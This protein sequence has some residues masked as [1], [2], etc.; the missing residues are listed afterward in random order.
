[1]PN[2][3][4]GVGSFSGVGLLFTQANADGYI[5]TA[6]ADSGR[7]TKWNMLSDTSSTTATFMQITGD[8][9]GNNPG[10][11]ANTP[12]AGYIQGSSSS[13]ATAR[14]TQKILF[15]T[16]VVSATAVTPADMGN[17]CGVANAGTAGYVMG[18]NVTNFT[19]ANK[20]TYSNETNSSV[21]LGISAT[22]LGTAHSNNGVAAY[23]ANGANASYSPTT[24]YQKIPYSTQSASSI[25]SL[26]TGAYRASFANSGTAGYI[27]GGLGTSNV[28]NAIT[29][30]AYSSDSLSTLSATLATA[31]YVH[32]GF[33]RSGTAGYFAQ[34]NNASYDATGSVEKLAFSND[35]IST[36][37]A[38]VVAAT[39]RSAFANSGTL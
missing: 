30:T 37:A 14:K 32:V 7:F 6:N 22:H 38:T 15:S 31:R 10:T 18:G 23:L 21:S 20:M 13:A 39:Q 35:T 11:H 1:M 25:T 36:Q 8:F 19:G 17:G 4:S 28:L 26:V 27:G 34:G 5:T 12:V 33:A 29:K 3:L 16:E 24:T 2:T 9:D